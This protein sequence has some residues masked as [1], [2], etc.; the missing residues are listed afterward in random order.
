MM[1][2][3]CFR[4]CDHVFISHLLMN[5]FWLNEHALINDFIIM[6]EVVKYMIY[7]MYL[8]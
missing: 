4:L 3:L 8:V 1:G 7:Y 2:P 5:L 6:A